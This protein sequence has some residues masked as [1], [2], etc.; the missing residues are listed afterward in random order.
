MK[1]YLTVVLLFACTLQSC[2]PSK[3]NKWVAHHYRDSPAESPH[4]KS[5]QIT[6]LS[7][8]PDFG[9]ALSH[10]EKNTSHLLPLLFYWQYDYK[11]TCTLN[12]QIA[13][14]HV[15]AGV[16]PYSLKLKQKLNGGRVELTIE[17]LPHIFAVDDKGHIIWV[18]LYA[19]GWDFL[20]IQPQTNDMVVSYR[21]LDAQGQE[22]KTGT[23]TVPDANKGVSLKVLQSVR[24][25]TMDYLDAY[26]A[27]I[28]MMTKKCMDQLVGQL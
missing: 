14:N 22:V 24:R 6:V 12:P 13:V 11:V 18:I 15:M 19:F 21:V 4:R 8:F 17:Q 1:R 9:I 16:L 25:M 26:D 20:T 23:L 5:D 3:M 7:K 27:T 28:N 2:L 10:T